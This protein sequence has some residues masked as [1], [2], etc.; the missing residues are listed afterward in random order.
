MHS[1]LLRLAPVR[2]L[3]VVPYHEDSDSTLAMV[4][5]LSFLSSHAS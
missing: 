3:A 2:Q 5:P 1:S 4:S